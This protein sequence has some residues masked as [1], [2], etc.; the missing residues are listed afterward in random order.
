VAP[1]QDM[2][3]PGQGFL[4]RSLTSRFPLDGPDLTGFC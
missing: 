1:Y 2:P 3:L 4:R